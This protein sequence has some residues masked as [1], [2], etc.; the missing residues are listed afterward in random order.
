LDAEYMARATFGSD[1]RLLVNSVLR[2]WDT[3]ALDEFI[4]A[5]ALDVQPL[6]ASSKAPRFSRPILHMPSSAVSKRRSET[7]QVSLV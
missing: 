1:L 7:E 6:S 2:R 5:T 3:A 4:V